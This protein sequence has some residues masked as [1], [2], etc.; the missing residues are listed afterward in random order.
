MY[1]AQP[2][3]FYRNSK[4]GQ[5][6]VIQVTSISQYIINVVSKVVPIQ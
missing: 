4:T 5:T 3:D 6:K 2:Y 1:I